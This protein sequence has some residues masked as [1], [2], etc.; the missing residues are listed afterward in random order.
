MES[1]TEYM[2]PPLDSNQESF[3]KDTGSH[4]EM[5]CQVLMGIGR[6]EAKIDMMMAEDKSEDTKEKEYDS[7]PELATN[8]AIHS[9]QLEFDL[10]PLF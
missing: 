5:M 8:P 9:T 6:L 4:G 3:S 7:G 1:M 10:P 2:A